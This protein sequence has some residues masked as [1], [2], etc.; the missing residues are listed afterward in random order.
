MD[1]FSFLFFI[2]EFISNNYKTVTKQLL[3]WFTILLVVLILNYCQQEEC[4]SWALLLLISLVYFQTFFPSIRWTFLAADFNWS[5]SL[6]LGTFICV[7]LSMRNSA[8]DFLRLGR[9][10]I[11][12]KRGMFTLQPARQRDSINSLRQNVGE[13]RLK[14]SWHEHDSF[15]DATGV[16]TRYEDIQPR[17]EF[18]QIARVIWQWRF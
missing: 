1:I 6:T 15:A 2:L 18:Q 11:A 16:S 5:I 13:T 3:H 8:R 12:K 9:A 10:F 17:R 4:F 14:R 7:G